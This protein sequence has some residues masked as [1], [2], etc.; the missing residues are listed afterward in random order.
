VSDGP[1]VIRAGF[2]ERILAERE[3]GDNREDYAREYQTLIQVREAQFHNLLKSY[4]MQRL[5]MP[6]V[7]EEKK[8]SEFFRGPLATAKRALKA[9]GVGEYAE[10][11]SNDLADIRKITLSRGDDLETTAVKLR[12]SPRLV[13][14]RDI[15]E[16]LSRNDAP[17]IR[18]FERVT[19]ARRSP[20]LDTQPVMVT[21]REKD[22][23]RLRRGDAAVT[24]AITKLR[25]L[26]PV[27]RSARLR[28]QQRPNYRE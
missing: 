23:D 10:F 24:E 28:T 5:G 27:R 26:R 14:N 7:V 1:R 15:V 22:L 8:R 18:A 6:G 25:D 19:E 2:S 9:I 3:E 17:T 13:A 4:G 12:E 20:R 11:V 21:M 16:K